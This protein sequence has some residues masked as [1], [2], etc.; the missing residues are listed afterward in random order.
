DVVKRNLASFDKVNSFSFSSDGKKLAM[1]A[2]KRGKGQSDIFVFGLNTSAVE[3]LTN[4]IWYD[5]NPVFVRNSKQIV[6]ESNRINDTVKSSDDANYALKHN[7]NTDL[8][9]A[10]YPFK[11]NVLV[12]VTNTPEVNETTP[13]AYTSNYITYLSDRTGI[14]NRYLAE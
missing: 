8:F 10:A 1:S 3:Q 9:M 13:Q 7:R 6:F 14:Y 12:R 2:V 11:N 4:D 5:N